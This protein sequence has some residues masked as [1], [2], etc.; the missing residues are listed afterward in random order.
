M[1]INLDQIRRQ[2]IVDAQARAHAKATELEASRDLLERVTMWRNEL[3]DATL[4]DGYKIQL[5]DQI[6]RNLDK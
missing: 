4:F 5:L 6:I 1:I 2:H 3:L